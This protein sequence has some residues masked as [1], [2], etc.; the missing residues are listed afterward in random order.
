M[1]T[2]PFF[3]RRFTS[4]SSASVTLVEIRFRRT[5]LTGFAGRPRPLVAAIVHLSIILRQ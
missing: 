1:G 2:P 5:W 4:A 3:A